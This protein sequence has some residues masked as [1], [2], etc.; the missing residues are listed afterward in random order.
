MEALERDEADAARS[1]RPAQDAWLHAPL[2]PLR[3]E[4]RRQVHGG[5]Y[6]IEAVRLAAEGR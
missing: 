4:P 2:A 3:Q 5:R 1:A 6:E